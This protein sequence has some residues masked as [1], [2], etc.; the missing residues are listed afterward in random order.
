[1][2]VA[3]PFDHTGTLDTSGWGVDSDS[4]TAD[5]T[6]GATGPQPFWVEIPNNSSHIICT[7]LA[8]PQP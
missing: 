4:I 1:M 6:P 3:Y 7:A 5:L 8:M 2:T